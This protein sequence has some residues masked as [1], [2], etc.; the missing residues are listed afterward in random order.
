M[1]AWYEV[2][3]KLHINFDNKDLKQNHSV[4][5]VILHELLRESSIRTRRQVDTIAS[6]ISN[7]P[8]SSHI[9]ASSASLPKLQNSINNSHTN[10]HNS[11]YNSTHNSHNNS[12]QAASEGN[13]LT[14]SSENISIPSTNN[15]NSN[16][17][18]SSISNQLVKVKP[19]RPATAG[20]ALDP[21]SQTRSRPH[22]DSN[23]PSYVKTKV[24]NQNWM[25]EMVRL[26]TI[27]RDIRLAKDNLD[28]LK[29]R[30]ETLNRQ[31]KRHTF[32]SD[33]DKAHAEEKCGS[34]KKSPCACCQQM[35]LYVNLPKAVTMKAMIDIRL[36]WSGNLKS[37]T[38]Y[39]SDW[40]ASTSN[41]DTA[42]VVS[43]A[44]RL[45]DTVRVCTFCAQFFQ[46]QESYRPSYGALVKEEKKKKYDEAVEREKEY[47]DPLKMCEK[48]QELLELENPTYISARSPTRS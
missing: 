5:E 47:W 32:K 44:P 3:S 21:K 11:I 23:T 36:L 6:C 41:S 22:M 26:Q 9:K 13:I 35:Y 16:I 12:Y 25:P 31:A 14:K 38:V 19:V 20:S 27:S 15:N 1:I 28:D 46:D 45:Y 18:N 37:S 17:V 29:M 39:N 43:V 42:K 33:L 8:Q 30:E 2:A 34:T 48:N 10:S 40:K 7:R 24:S 4:M